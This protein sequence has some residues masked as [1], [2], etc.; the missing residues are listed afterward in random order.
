MYE[1]TR[2]QR[3]ERLREISRQNAMA[4]SMPN[5]PQQKARDEV[6]G[7]AKEPLVQQLSGK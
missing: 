4:F 7:K 6:L 5:G 1:N 3:Y 2:K